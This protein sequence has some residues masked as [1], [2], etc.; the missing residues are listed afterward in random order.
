MSAPVLPIASD[1]RAAPDA[2]I[3]HVMP[4]DGRHIAART[5]WCQPQQL[6]DETI[7]M[8]R[9]VAEA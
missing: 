5:C 1:Q 2:E 4:D 9:R 3:T 6:A 7:W 8:H